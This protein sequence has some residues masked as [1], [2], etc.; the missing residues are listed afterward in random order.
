ML[1]TL[2][3]QRKSEA[4]LLH[5]HFDLRV[6]PAALKAAAG[7][8]VR[9]EDAENVVAGL[10]ESGG[11]GRFAGKGGGRL[12]LGLDFFDRGSLVVERDCAGAAEL[13]PTQ[14]DGSR[15]RTW[16]AGARLGIVGDPDGDRQRGRRR[17]GER[18]AV[19]AWAVYARAVLV[20]ADERGR[21][22]AGFDERRDLP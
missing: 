18:L 2:R 4:T 10:A 20:E 3:S 14:G 5:R 13:A 12:P 21:V 17:R 6:R 22:A 9:R 7:G 11:R 8:P 19:A 16:K 15:S 1:R